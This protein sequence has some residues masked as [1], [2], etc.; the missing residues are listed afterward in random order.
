[1]AEEERRE[2]K[3]PTQVLSRLDI[4]IFDDRIEIYEHYSSG[5]AEKLTALLENLGVKVDKKFCS[6]CG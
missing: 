6:P 2:R 1:M 5:Q 3:T 4:E